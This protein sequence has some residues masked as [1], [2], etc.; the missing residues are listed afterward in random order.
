MSTIA[1]IEQD[2]RSGVLHRPP[3]VWEDVPK[4]AT[5]LAKTHT[6]GCRSLDILHCAA[7]DSLSATCFVT[8]DAR[9]R[10]L[11]LKL[12]LACPSV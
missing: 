11:A 1:L 6:L 3:L 4:G 10:K 2:T 9:Q 5:V 12:G 7:A 8:T